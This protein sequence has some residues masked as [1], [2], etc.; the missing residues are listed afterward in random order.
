MAK[1]PRILIEFIDWPADS[2]WKYPD[3][4]LWSKG[5]LHTR[6]FLDDE[7]VFHNGNVTDASAFDKVDHLANAKIGDE[8]WVETPDVFYSED[9]DEHIQVWRRCKVVGLEDLSEDE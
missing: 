8:V 5:P 2:L 4:Y 7:L 1:R 6:G 3:S 9:P